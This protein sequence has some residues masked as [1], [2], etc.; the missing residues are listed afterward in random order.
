MPPAALKKIAAAKAPFAS[1][2][3]DSGTHKAELQL[4]KA[5]GVD[6]K[7]ASGTWYR[8]TGSG[9]G[10]TLNTA[11]A[12]ERLRAHRSRHLAQLPR[13]A[14]TSRSWSKATAS[15]STSTASCWSTRPSSPNVKA[16]LGQQFVDWLISP[17]GQK[18]IAG[19]KING[20]QLFFPNAKPQAS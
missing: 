16:E 17:E 5:A 19:Y 2:G 20:E 10:P 4:W 13:T 6:T 12:H 15:C 7:A 14:A 18:A 3:D 1:R 9:M 8:E 11:A